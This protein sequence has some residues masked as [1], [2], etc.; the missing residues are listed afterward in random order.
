VFKAALAV[1]PA[2]TEFKSLIAL[3]DVNGYLLLI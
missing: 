1:M 2:S 3:S